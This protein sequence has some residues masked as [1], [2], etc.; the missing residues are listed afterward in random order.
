MNLKFFTTCL[1]HNSTPA[2]DTLSSMFLEKDVSQSLIIN[3]HEVH[4][5]NRQLSK[6]CCIKNCQNSWE[7]IINKKQYLIITIG[8]FEPNETTFHY[9]KKF[10]PNI[11]FKNLI[12]SLLKPVQKKYRTLKVV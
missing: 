9:I 5:H 6:D 4:I 7:E 2:S 10:P 12:H 11:I 1:I 3:L 8:K